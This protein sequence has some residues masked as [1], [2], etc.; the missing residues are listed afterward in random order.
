MDK[1][2]TTIGKDVIESLT[3]GMYEDA[4]TIYREYIQNSA[5]QIDKAVKLGILSSREEGYIE[6]EID[7]DR[8]TITISDNATGIKASEA[9]AIL[10]NIAK[11]TKQRGV[12]KG[13]RGIGRLG[14][15]GYCNKLTFE[16][17]YFGEKVQTVMV[18]FANN[19]KNI[20]GDRSH[21]EE[22][23]E[24]IDKVTKFVTFPEEENAHYFKVTL[25]K[26]SNDLL[27]DKQ[28]IRDYLSMIAPVTFHP[29]FT[30]VS[31]I[32]RYCKE[33]QFSLDEYK[34]AV[35]GDPIY[36]AYTS[37]IYE[38]EGADKKAIDELKELQF[39]KFNAQDYNLL[40]WGWYGISDFNKQIPE[41][42]NLAR[43]LRLRKGN[44]QI[45]DEYCLVKF[46]KEQRGNFY[47][48]G[49]VHASHID[50]LPNARR[51]YFLE[52]EVTNLFEER[53]RSLFGEIHKVYY[54]ASKVRN[55]Q[56]RITQ[57][58]EFTKEYEEKSQSGF[59]NVE[60]LA[61]FTKK[62]EKLTEEAEKAKKELTKLSNQLKEGTP[63]KRVFDS[64]TKPIS[65]ESPVANS[66]A[67][68]ETPKK[69]KFV[70]EDLKLSYTER[71]LVARLFSVVE[72][73][74]TEKLP[75]KDMVRELAENIKVR[76][77][78]E[79]NK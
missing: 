44:I 78:E 73:V 39:F 24:V 37:K 71:K 67:A 64:I 60:Q 66:P 2:Q 48:L 17:S 40:C 42:A 65:M 14:G 11:S 30:F 49:E 25:E 70:F 54:F 36:K 51:D 52:N 10:R 76:I 33:N 75:D 5:D 58:D 22:A 3:L 63:Q 18:W 8:R 31:E 62:R 53:L 12:D 38:G 23:A 15:L 7:K 13:F 32:R 34:I 46:H 50:L 47:F 29:R 16:T 1:H 21:Q 28:A 59:A 55:T 77:F 41:K 4:R 56:K 57:R 6:I 35:N 43:G 74:L 20:I 27:L 69:I 19:L 26:V 45:G 68:K 61:D 72:K 9:V 79:F